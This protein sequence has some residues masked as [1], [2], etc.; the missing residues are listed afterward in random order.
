MEKSVL[1]VDDETGIVKALS[2]TLSRAG[3]NVKTAHSGAEALHILDSA[4]VMVLLTDFRMPEMNGAELLAAVKQRYPEIV[5]LVISGYS[6]FSSVKNLLNAGSAFRFLQKPWEEADLLQHID[7]AFSHYQQSR[8]VKQSQNM[9]LTTTDAL[10]ELS[11]SGEILQCNAAANALLNISQGTTTVMLADYLL[12]DDKHSISA[13]IFS[14]KLTRFITLVNRT[15]LEVSCR[16]KGPKSS[17]LELVTVNNNSLLNSVFDMPSMLNYQQLLGLVEQYMQGGRSLALAAIKIRSFDIWSRVIGYAEAERAL[18]FIAEQLLGSVSAVGELAFLANEQFVLMLPDSAIEMDVLQQLAKVLEP[19][20]TSSKLRNRSADF[21]VSYC[22]MPDDGDE[23]RAALNNLLLGNMLV[24]ENAPSMFMRYDHQAVERKKHQLSLSQALHYAVE[25][26]QLFLHFQPK[27]DL[28]A[29]KLSGCEA[30]LRWHHPEFGLVSPALFIPLAEQH[31]QIIE[32]G[33]WVLKQAFKTLAT[34][35]KRLINT[36]K[37]AVNISG[38]QLM[39]PGFID[40]VQQ[41]VS[42]SGVDATQLELE[43]TETFLLDNLDECCRKLNILSELGISIAIDDFGTGYSSLAY[44]NKL[45]VK[46]LK[47]DRS[48][49][50]DIE[51]NISTQSLVTN[52]VRLSHDMNMQVVVEG[53]ETLDQLNIVKGMGCDVIQGFCISR[54]QS[55][56]GYIALLESSDSLSAAI[57]HG[58]VHV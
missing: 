3:Y 46:V 44:L 40:W 57:S 11:V 26:E 47:I 43:I 37:M 41:Q 9:L 29:F 25:H 54:P 17:I 51:S 23:A 39:E 31:G 34:W 15:E 13:H 30:L 24:A 38:R 10:I 32:I 20:A 2:R 36:G 5:C 27:F 8:F 55:E 53:V 35:Q 52:I 6:D 45:P 21:A 28:K 48:L 14:E 19:V 49:I 56:Q 16:L 22:L 50:V 12:D 42:H 4:S 18:E 58:G 1:V 7:D 33:Y